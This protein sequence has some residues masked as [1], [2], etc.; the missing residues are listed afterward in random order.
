[1]KRE[2]DKS[3]TT[4]VTVDM[5]K[6]AFVELAVIVDALHNRR[7]GSSLASL[8]APGKQRQRGTEDDRHTE[9][10]TSV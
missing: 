9:N 3:N 4:L 6:P 7:L 2:R 8:A 1:M 10:I 5:G